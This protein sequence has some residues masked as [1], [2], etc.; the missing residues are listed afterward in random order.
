MLR[1]QIQHVHDMPASAPKLR[2]ELLRQQQRRFEMDRHQ[3]T[4]A[5][6]CGRPQIS[7]LV[8]GRAVDQHIQPP[9]MPLN[10]LENMRR[11][12]RGIREIG[13]NHQRLGA[14][15]AEGMFER[16]DFV[17]TVKIRERDIEPRFRQPLDDRPSDAFRPSRHQ[18][19]LPLRF[20]PRSI[21]RQAPAACNGKKGISGPVSAAQGQ[22]T[23]ED[24][25]V[26]SG[27][28]VVYAKTVSNTIGVSGSI[29][30][31]LAPETP[32]CEARVPALWTFL[33]AG[34]QVV[35]AARTLPATSVP[36]KPR[37]S[38]ALIRFLQSGGVSQTELYANSGV[39]GSPRDML[40]AGVDLNNGDV[41]HVNV[42]Y[43]GTTLYESVTDATNPA[44]PGFTASYTIDI[45]AA[46]GNNRYAWAGFT[47][48]TGADAAGS[49]VQNVP[50][51]ELHSHLTLCSD[52]RPASDQHL[53]K[54]N[55]I[56]AGIAEN[57]PISMIFCL[58]NSARAA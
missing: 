21:P 33:G 8:D 43:D 19:H 54:A 28:G 44:H 49:A 42:S 29:H 4:K 30:A 37:K 35:S 27:S 31:V 39:V 16:E 58:N 1:Q 5:L 22:L 18:G 7:G 17:S 9:V 51:N 10:G 45:Q 56:R 38:Y 2:L 32:G 55:H 57:R 12:R 34:A 15:F 52:F 25:G 48:A 46:L 20:H 14:A 11:G 40:A 36:A 41:Y 26:G 50:R 3:R 53:C 13:T 24:K 47:A 23:D 6:E